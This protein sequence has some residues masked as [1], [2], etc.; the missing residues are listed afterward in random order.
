MSVK[1]NLFLSLISLVLSAYGQ[2]N[3]E[4][5]ISKE[6]VPAGNVAQIKLSSTEPKPIIHGSMF[7][8]LSVDILGVALNSPQGTAA[9]VAWRKN[10][11]L[12]MNINDPSATL[13]MDPDYPF[14][15]IAVRVNSNIAPGT[16]IP[17]KMDASQWKGP[18]GVPYQEQTEP[19]FIRVGG[20]LAINNVLPGGGRIPAGGT[21]RIVGTGFTPGTRVQIEDVEDLEATFID[22]GEFL[23]KTS[24]AV[25]LAGK[26]IRIRRDKAEVFYFSY[27][28]G[29]RRTFSNVPLFAQCDPIFPLRSVLRGISAY[30]L[31]SPGQIAGVALQNPNRTANVV[32]VALLSAFYQP[33]AQ[34][35]I[36]LA[37]G[38]ELVKSL[39]EL[40][41]VPPSGAAFVHIR[42]E[43]PVQ[44]V[45]LL[46]NPAA[47]QLQPLSFVPLPVNAN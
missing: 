20:N 12:L 17:V 30:P 41:S 44:Y 3:L 43:L 24:S 19:G 6:V 16:F 27:L 33:L 28:R 38:E 14:L 47:T 39:P 35:S 42:S 25:D 37:P 15:T 32:K 18:G 10:G 36:T 29:V 31:M 5:R 7:L 45:P 46:A 2:Q 13:G 34:T 40:L 23:M 26:R 11:R 9:G 8:D 22:S 1:V 21:F 4:L